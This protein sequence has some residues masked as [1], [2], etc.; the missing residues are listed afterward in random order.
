[1]KRL[2]GTSAVALAAAAFLA[3][4]SLVAWRQG[5]ALELL[6]EQD[7]VQ[8]EWALG[9]AEQDELQRRVRSL[10]S[11]GYVVPEAQRRMGMRMPA[12]SEIV[13]LAGGRS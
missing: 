1:M 9:V 7:R 3:S 2:S 10:E 8:R 4:L 11:R 12:A 13:I 6:E 5:R